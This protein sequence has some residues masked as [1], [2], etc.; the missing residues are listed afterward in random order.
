MI[1][2]ATCNAADTSGCADHPPTITIGAFPSP[3]VINPATGTVYVSYGSTANR[4][5][6]VNAA[7]CNAGDT[8]GCG[9]TP[10]AV[11]VGKGTF[12]S[13]SAPRPTRSTRR[14]MGLASP[15]TRSR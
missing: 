5:A 13:R 11:K 9:Q 1:N 12:A 4:V 10:A 14:T 15:A 8:S 7:T 6:V 2:T 3:P